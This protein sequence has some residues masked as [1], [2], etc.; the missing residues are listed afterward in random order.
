MGVRLNVRKAYLTSRAKSANRW[1]VF[2]IHSDSRT[3]L[4]VAKFQSGKPPGFVG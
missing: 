1:G 3:F 4:R 2:C